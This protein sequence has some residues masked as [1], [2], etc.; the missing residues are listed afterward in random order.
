M[1]SAKHSSSWLAC[2]SIICCCSN[3]VS[4]VVNKFK[5]QVNGEG[6]SSSKRSQVNMIAHKNVTTIESICSLVPG[7]QVSLTV[8]CLGLR[9]TSSSWCK[10]AVSTKPGRK[11]RWLKPLCSFR[12]SGRSD[13]VSCAPGP[14]PAKPWPVAGIWEAARQQLG[15]LVLSL[16]LCFSC[17]S[18][19]LSFSSFLFNN[20]LLM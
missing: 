13:L 9:P 8:K 14:V 17:P 3:K 6:Q 19:F 1:R 4:C 12:L 11:W 2:F 7:T 18:I 15:T 16:P 10:P 20:Y 5:R